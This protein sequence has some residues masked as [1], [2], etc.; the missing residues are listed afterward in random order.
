MTDGSTW[1]TGWFKS[2]RSSNAAGCVEIRFAPSTVDVR[3]S[4]DREGPMLSVSGQ[5]WQGFVAGARAGGYGG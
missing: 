3:D 2:S 1:T 4:K 5:A